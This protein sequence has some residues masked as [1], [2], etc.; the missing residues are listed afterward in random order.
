MGVLSYLTIPYH[1]RWECGGVVG[2]AYNLS[3]LSESTSFSRFS[4]LKDFQLQFCKKEKRE[5]NNGK[6]KA[7]VCWSVIDFSIRKGGSC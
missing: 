6:K 1:L 4:A 3:S 5:E 7:G 2:F